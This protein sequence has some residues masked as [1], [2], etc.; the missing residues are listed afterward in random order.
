MARIA[1]V[2]GRY[3]RLWEAAVNVED[4]GLQFAD[5]VYEVIPVVGGR[6]IDEAPH[7]DRLDR[8]LGE[9]QLA[10]AMSRCALTRVMRQVVRR[11]RI[12]DG[13]L[14]MQFTRG[15]AR[16]DPVFPPDA[17]TT[18]IM[19]A[20]RAPAPDP[21]AVGGV[22]I[23]T[24]PDIRW[25]RRDIKTVQLLPNLLAKNRAR[26]AGFHDAWL[27]D[28]DALVTEGSASNAW[29]VTKDKQLVTRAR[30]SDILWGVTRRRAIALAESLAFD[31][32]ERPFTVPEAKAAAEAFLTSASSYVLPVTR[33]DEAVIGDGNAGPLTTALVERYHAF[34]TDGSQAA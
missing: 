32:V 29:I 3:V 6:L 27:V 1:Y 18:V 11:N 26:A 22:S 7:L 30:S 12:R 16:R 8:S 5:S 17:E 23:M 9:L 20:R 28:D 2:N 10:P 31:F 34:M 14:Y 33:I 21:S 25:R 19:T 4:R 24:V 15:A 13:V